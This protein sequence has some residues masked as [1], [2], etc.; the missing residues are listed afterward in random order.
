MARYKISRERGLR[1][2]ET[3]PA[4]DVEPEYK[5]LPVFHVTVTDRGRLVLPAEIREKLKIRDGDPVALILQDDGLVT[6][7]TREV[8]LQRFTGMLK[9]PGRG[10]LASDGLIAERRREARREDRNVREWLKRHHRVK[11]R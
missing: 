8:A 11:R 7:Q 10:A 4:D 5:P 2:R 3:A 9:H 6:L 1:V